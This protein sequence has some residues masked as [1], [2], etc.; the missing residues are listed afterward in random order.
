M[1]S[2][3]SVSLKKNKPIE[4]GVNDTKVLKGH[5]G[6]AMI[7]MQSFGHIDLRYLCQNPKQE[8][9]KPLRTYRSHPVNR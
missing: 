4:K 6:A 2:Q 8:K 3:G 7:S 5:N 9:N 1:L